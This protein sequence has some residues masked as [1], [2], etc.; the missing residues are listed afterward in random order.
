MLG[1]IYGLDGE[2]VD[3]RTDEINDKKA[4][5][6]LSKHKVSQNTEVNENFKP[7]AV[8]VKVEMKLI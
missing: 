6:E 3:R 8:Q 2:V 4:C 7:G 5:I 1:R